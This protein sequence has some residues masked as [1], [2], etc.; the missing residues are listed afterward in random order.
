MTTW[1]PVRRAVYEVPS[2]EHSE[3]K[4]H[5][6]IKVVDTSCDITSVGRGASTKALNRNSQFYLYTTCI[7]ERATIKVQSESRET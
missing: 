7:V 2:C 5:A 4:E 6:G 3:E 1:K